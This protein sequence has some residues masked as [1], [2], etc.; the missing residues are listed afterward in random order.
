MKRIRKAIGAFNALATLHPGEDNT[1]SSEHETQQALRARREDMLTTVNQILHDTAVELRLPPSAAQEARQKLETTVNRAYSIK[2]LFHTAYGEWQQSNP[3]LP[4]TYLPTDDQLIRATRAEQPGVIDDFVTLARR[5]R[6]VVENVKR[7]SDPI[8]PT[9]IRIGFTQEFP[10]AEEYV[11]AHLGPVKRL[12]ET[13]LNGH[14]LGQK[15]L[16]RSLPLRTGATIDSYRE[17][18]KEAERKRQAQ[19]AYREG[20]AEL[21]LEYTNDVRKRQAEHIYNHENV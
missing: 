11:H 14:G 8:G 5:R 6:N 1:R 10:H 7:S 16:E 2:N 13:P 15:A 19:M 3:V 9:D 17:R 21:H 12:H 20:L 4:Q 18:A